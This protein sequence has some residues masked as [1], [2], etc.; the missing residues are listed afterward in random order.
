MCISYL[1]D[2]Y[3]INCSWLLNDN[4]FKLHSSTY[5]WAHRLPQGSWLSVCM[6]C[7]GCWPWSLLHSSGHWCQE[8]GQGYVCTQLDGLTASE[9]SGAGQW[10]EI[11]LIQ[12]HSSCK[13]SGHQPDLPWLH[14][15][16]TC[17]AVKAS[18]RAWAEGEQAHSWRSFLQTIPVVCTGMR[19]DRARFR[20]TSSCG[21]LA[22]SMDFH[23]RKSLPGVCTWHLR[24]VMNI[25]PTA[26]KCTAGEAS[27]N[28][29]GSA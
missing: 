23:S 19:G 21:A 2:S 14:V 7:W 29:Q 8:S 28:L 25:R 26:C 17:M 13:G 5:M 16:S 22:V 1:L 27:F 12:N 10:Q 15:L 11:G 4:G 18:D 6:H 20:T 9:W 24:P 3:D